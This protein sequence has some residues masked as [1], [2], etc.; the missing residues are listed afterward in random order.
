[1]TWAP[2]GKT[3]TRRPKASW[4][5]AVETER[6]KGEHGH[7]EMREERILWTVIIGKT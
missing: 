2:E 7:H 1:M 4:R 3:K 5:R 6:E